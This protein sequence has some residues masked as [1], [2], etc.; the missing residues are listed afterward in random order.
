[1][2]DMRSILDELLRADA[3]SQ[4]RRPA[5]NPG[6]A[7][8]AP[9]DPQGGAQH[10]SP[11]TAHPGTGDPAAP[12][13]A[14]SGAAPAPS[15]AGDPAGSSLEDLL[16]GVLGSGNQRQAMGFGDPGAPDLGEL[17]ARLSQRAGQ[18]GGDVLDALGQVL[19][20]ATAGV[21]EAT[22]ALDA[23][24]GASKYSRETIEQITGKSADEVLAQ[25]KALLAENRLGA[26]A[27]LGG[28][29]AL[30][31]GTQAGRSLGCHGGPSSAASP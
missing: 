6:E 19:G 29:D 20:Q 8:L 1:M 23:T 24:T 2:L 11:P 26:A 16:R 30:V 13:W 15:P 9:R 12:N 21:R 25:V 14:P 4:G 5:S 18:L 31:L 27:A 3:R 17:G 7:E 22:G 28:L 10:G